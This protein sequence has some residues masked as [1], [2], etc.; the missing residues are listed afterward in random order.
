MRKPKGRQGSERSTTTPQDE[1]EDKKEDEKE[2]EDMENDQCTGS[3]LEDNAAPKK[4]KKE[5]TNY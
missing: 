2:E 3:E 4:R 5:R 1:N